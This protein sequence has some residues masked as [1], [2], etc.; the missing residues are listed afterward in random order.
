MNKKEYAN[1]FPI[2][3]NVM[4]LK[5]V[6]WIN[7]RKMK[8]DDLNIEIGFDEIVDAEQRLKRFASYL[9]GAFNEE[10]FNGIIESPIFKADNIKGALSENFLGEVY[11]KRDDLLSIAGSVKARGGI[12]EVLKHAEDL[13]I[14]NDLI[15]YK[16]DYKKILNNEIR[17]FFSKYTISVG[18]TGNLGLSIGIMGTKLGFN[19]EVHMSMDAKKWKKDLLRKNG[20]KVFEYESDYSNAVKEGRKKASQDPNNYFVDDENSMN[21]F[22]GYAVA[23]LRLEKQL[24]ESNIEISKENKLIVYIPCGVGGG[25]SGIAYGLKLIYK[26]NVEIFFVEPT[27][28]PCMLISMVTGLGNKIQ[29]SD[30][31]ID[32]ITAADGLAVG[33]ASA[34]ATKMMENILDGIYTVEDKKLFE[35]LRLL[36]VEEEI[37]IEP[38]ATAGLIGIENNNKKGIHLIWS[39]GGKL[40][41]EYEFSKYLNKKI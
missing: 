29:V 28:S 9:Q 1:E 40:V 33:R 5:E 30:L 11:I 13:L 24:K 4:D 16:D 37:K 39:T 19:V 34:L 18:S 23:G 12:Y 22:L 27:H 8:F 15:S 41:P 20:A 21:L 35:Y 7:D 14:K 17:N 26:D 32:N 36:Y 31:G 10:E 38:S 3:E 6:E 2:L 25:P